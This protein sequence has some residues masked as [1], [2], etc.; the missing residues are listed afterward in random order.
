MPSNSRRWTRCHPSIT[1]T[2]TMIN[3]TVARRNT[4]TCRRGIVKTSRRKAVTNPCR[5][6]MIENL[7]LGPS[8]GPSPQCASTSFVMMKAPRR[9]CSC[10]FVEEGSSVPTALSG[11]R[12]AFAVSATTPHGH[13]VGPRTV[14]QAQPNAAGSRTQG[15]HALPTY[16][17]GS[18]YFKPPSAISDRLVPSGGRPAFLSVQSMQI[19]CHRTDL[20][21]PLLR[22]VDDR[23]DA[24]R[25]YECHPPIVTRVWIS[26]RAHKHDSV[27]KRG[28]HGL[29]GGEQVITA[30][31]DTSMLRHEDL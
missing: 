21:F 2:S 6:L 10:R 16:V 27:A 8:D 31:R 26:I 28:R 13:R 9:V 29:S 18:A 1:S 3:K 22:I 5:S 24:S 17:R 14:S 4:N 25:Q 20:S 19:E 7:L 11:R 15:R 23:H 12:T 30:F